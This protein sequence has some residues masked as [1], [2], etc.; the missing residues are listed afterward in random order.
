VKALSRDLAERF[1][2]YRDK[3]PRPFD[4]IVI[5]EGQEFTKRQVEALMWLLPDP[6]ISPVYVFA[7]PFQHSGIFS[8]PPSERRKNKARYRWESPLEAQMVA[9]TTNCRNS[10]PIANVAAR[11]YPH[12]G[13]TA[14]VDG[15]PPVFHRVAPVQGPVGNLQSR[16]ETRQPGRPN[17]L[18]TR[19]ST[20]TGKRSAI[21]AARRIY[22]Q[23]RLDEK[24]KVRIPTSCSCRT[25]S[26]VE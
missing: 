5:D 6:D 2:E 23:L 19:P 21:P 15:P 4:A 10:S 8:T 17:S 18:A 25:S 24:T 11:F 16:R 12:A 3:L 26:T 22:S 9:L 20:R 14:I 1:L 7:D 13:P